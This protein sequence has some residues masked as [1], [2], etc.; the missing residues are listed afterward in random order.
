MSIVYE[1]LRTHSCGPNKYGY[2]LANCWDRIGT[3]RVCNECG[4]G[5]V[6]VKS[7]DPGVMV[8]QWVREGWFARRR[9][10]RRPADTGETT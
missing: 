7:P 9:R 2:W 1:P 4:R 3:V 10:L 5:W 8:R 6:A